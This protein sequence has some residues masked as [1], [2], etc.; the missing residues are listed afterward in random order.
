VPIG[1]RLEDVA[2]LPVLLGET[3]TG[4]AAGRTGAATV[5]PLERPEGQSKVMMLTTSMRAWFST[6]LSSTWAPV[7]SSPVVL[8]GRV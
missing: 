8:V 4:V 7:V 3:R 5:V 1:E 6:A 2:E